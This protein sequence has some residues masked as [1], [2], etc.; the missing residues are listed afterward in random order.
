MSIYYMTGTIVYAG[1]PWM[2]NLETMPLLLQF[3]F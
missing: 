1:E 3:T 2:G